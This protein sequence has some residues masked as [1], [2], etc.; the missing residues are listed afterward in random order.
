MFQNR[1]KMENLIF[2]RSGAI[3]YVPVNVH[4]VAKADGTGRSK[5]TSVFESLCAV[6]EIYLDQEIQFY[7]RNVNF[8]NNTALYDNPSSDLGASWSRSISNSYRN[9]LNFFIAKVARAEELGVL[10]F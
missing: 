2:P 7:V 9:G 3:R 1:E 8:V 6:N 4:L 5:L 10:A